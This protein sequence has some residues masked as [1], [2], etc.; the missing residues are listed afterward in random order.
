MSPP[1]GEERFQLSA[2]AC[3]PSWCTISC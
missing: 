3:S 1:Y 2:T